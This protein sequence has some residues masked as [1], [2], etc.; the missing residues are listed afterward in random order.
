MPTLI[1]FSGSN[2]YIYVDEDTTAVVDA[3]AA[4]NVAG[5]SADLTQIPLQ[6]DAFQ[7]APV[8]VNPDRVAY[9]RAA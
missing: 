7:P 9:V 3:L 5:L 2:D 8:M 6:G 4:R 1:A